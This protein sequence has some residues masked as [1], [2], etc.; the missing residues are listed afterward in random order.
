MI[1]KFTYIFWGVTVLFASC[2]K[3]EQALNNG[4]AMID[5]SLAGASFADGSGVDGLSKASGHRQQISFDFPGHD[6][7]E[8]TIIEIPFDGDTYL[9]GKLRVDD[10]VISSGAANRGGQGLSA[11]T[12]TT[13]PPAEYL[14][15]GT[16]YRVV[17]Y[18]AGGEYVTDVEYSAGSETPTQLTLDP[19]EYTFAAYSIGSTSEVPVA[20]TGTFTN[21]QLDL[22]GGNGDLMYWTDTRQVVAGNN[23]LAITLRHKFVQLTVRINQGDYTNVTAVSGVVGSRHYNN[24][25]LKFNTGAVTLTSINASGKQV[26]FPAS[27]L[28]GATATSNPTM[29]WTDVFPNNRVVI[30]SLTV[31]GVTKT[32]LA[33][34]QLDLAP[35][36]RYTLSLTPR[37]GI[38]LGNKVWARGNL[39][40]NPSTGIYYFAEDQYEVGNYWKWANLLPVS[41]SNP[42]P[43]NP[44]ALNTGGSFPA[45]DPC[46]KVTTG[47]GGW[48]TPLG[49][50]MIR[51]DGEA[52]ND[53]GYSGYHYYAKLDDPYNLTPMYW[54]R[55]SWD[56]SNI[57]LPDHGY[58]PSG[59]TV[60][61]TFPTYNS[62]TNPINDGTT[63]TP[64]PN[65][66]STCVGVNGAGCRAGFYRINGTTTNG[67]NAVTPNSSHMPYVH[68]IFQGYTGVNTANHYT[69]ARQR[70]YDAFAASGWGVQIRCV[71]DRI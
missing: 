67:T 16:K 13:N 5:I 54:F 49:R 7:A 31:G 51:P 35:G 64:P 66:S 69:F 32:N 25:S 58:I 36:T 59:T 4:Q 38:V 62:S 68:H 9:V 52:P 46:S 28:G 29:L 34:E 27:S 3:D 61:H 63:I 15:A 12:T 45:N 20:P 50:D 23:Q 37:A 30:G 70:Q 44:S 17:V 42:V 43:T 56:P 6:E 21:A 40:Y 57:A 8:S 65:S 41:S 1:K 11:S 14:P 22:T 39:K 55:G 24:A 19:G 71:K 18:D 60:S 2:T 10:E 53:V 26:V 48:R 33:I 47:G